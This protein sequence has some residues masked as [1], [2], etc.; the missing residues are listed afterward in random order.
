[1]LKRVIKL[2]CQ[3]MFCFVFIKYSSSIIDSFFISDL[4]GHKIAAIFISVVLTFLILR[5]STMED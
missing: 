1:M 3:Y 2:A 4:K 5:G